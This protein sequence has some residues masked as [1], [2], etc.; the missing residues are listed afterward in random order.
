MPFFA[1]ATGKKLCSHY[2]AWFQGN[3][4]IDEAERKCLESFQ[5]RSW[6]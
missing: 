2:E 6:N 4:V 1:E 5:R 3:S